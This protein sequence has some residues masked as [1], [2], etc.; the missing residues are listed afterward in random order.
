MPNSTYPRTTVAAIIAGL[1]G[2]IAAAVITTLTVTTL[3]ATTAVI[4]TSTTQTANITNAAVT[5]T[6]TIAT[7]EVSTLHSTSTRVGYNGTAFSLSKAATSTIDP[8]SLTALQCT[9]TS[10]TATGA[11]AGDSVSPIIP[12]AWQELNQ[13]F[14][15]SAGTDALVLSQC[16]GSSTTV[17]VGS[18]AAGARFWH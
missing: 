5:G 10:I 3:T 9:S 12:S 4:G 1:A 14:T 8:N 11:V 6:A 13:I 2:G 7:G 18:G 17:D 15:V 16:N